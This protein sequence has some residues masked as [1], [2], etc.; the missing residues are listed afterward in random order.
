MVLP[1]TYQ[2]MANPAITQNGNINPITVQ[3]V[4]KPADNEKFFKDKIVKLQKTV[5]MTITANNLLVASEGSIKYATPPAINDKILG[6]QVAVL[7]HC[8]QIPKNATFSP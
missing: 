1:L 2:V 5:R 8:S 6:Y 3:N 4:A 7:I